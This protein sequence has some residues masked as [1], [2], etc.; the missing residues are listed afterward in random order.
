MLKELM[1]RIKHPSPREEQ[2]EGKKA[3]K[4]LKMGHQK[5]SSKLNSLARKSPKQ[6]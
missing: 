4:L 3:L 2:Q 6:G 5:M 1:G